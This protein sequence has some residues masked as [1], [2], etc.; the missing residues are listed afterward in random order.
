MSYIGR[1]I[2]ERTNVIQ[3]V[4]FQDAA[5]D[6]GSGIGVVMSRGSSSVAV[7]VSE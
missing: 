3:Y 4:A 7:N 6:V 2:Q 1:T 5:M